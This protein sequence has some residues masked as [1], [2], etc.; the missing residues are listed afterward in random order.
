MTGLIWLIV[1]A[2]C[3]AVE[4]A[5]YGLVTIWFAGGALI[6]F[7]VSFF[8]DN[9]VIQ[10]IVFLVVST[11]LLLF[12]RPVAVK[13]IN[14]KRTK[15][16]VDSVIGMVCKVTETI[17]N[18]NETGTVQLNGLEWTARSTG[19]EMISVGTK[20]KICSVSG[21]KVFVEEVK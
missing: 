14:G 13:L 3:L 17:D 19:G 2:V 10:I 1:L 15:T 12:T 20:V 7:L 9:L 8:T 18:F 6:S 4:A 11:I 16:N 21:V 5:T